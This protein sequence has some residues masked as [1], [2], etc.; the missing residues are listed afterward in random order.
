MRAGEL[1]HRVTIERA[2]EGSADAA[3][4]KSLTW[5]TLR[6]V[7]M[8]M[9]FASGREGFDGKAF[10]AAGVYTFEGRYPTGITVTPADRL[11]LGS[12]IFDIES[13]ADPDGKRRELAIVARERLQ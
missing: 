2:T 7:A 10:T 11:T 6:T 12:R 8:S 9:T 13:V 5:S 3:N 1:R 4:E